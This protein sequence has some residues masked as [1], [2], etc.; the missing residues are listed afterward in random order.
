VPAGTKGFIVE[1]NVARCFLMSSNI[2]HMRHFF[3]S[4]VIR[5]LPAKP[6]FGLWL[7]T[8]GNATALE[9]SR[10]L[11]KSVEVMGAAPTRCRG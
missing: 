3:V 8:T 9:P 11:E 2:G 10:T 4:S 7:L 1:P 5:V 6:T